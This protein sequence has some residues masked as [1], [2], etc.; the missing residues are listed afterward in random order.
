VIN[1]KTLLKKVPVLSED[2]DKTVREETKK[3]MVEFLRW[4]GPAFKP[5]L[6]SVKELIVKEVEA[7]VEKCTEKPKQTRYLRSQQVRAERSA[8]EGGD[9]DEELDGEVPEDEAVPDIDPFELLDPVDILSKLPKDFYEKCEAKKWQERKEA[10]EA[11]ETLVANPK[12]EPGDYGDLVRILKRIIGKDTN[13]V[14]VAIAGKCVTGLANGLKKKFSPYASSCIST[15]LEKFKEKKANV[16]TAMREAI[17]ACFVS[18]S[19]EAIQEDAVAALQNKNPQ[20]KM[21]TN[22][23]L[24][25]TFSKT[26][27]KI[28]SDKKLMKPYFTAIVVNLNESDPNV[29]DAAAEAIGVAMKHLGE[30]PLQPFISELEPIKLA[31]VKEM[32]EKAVITAPKEKAAKSAAPKA[33]PAKAAAAKPSGAKVVKKPA[34]AAKKPAPAANK[35]DSRD[36]D[37]MNNLYNARSEEELGSPDGQDDPTG[38]DDEGI[39]R[40]DI[41]GQITESLLNELADKNWKTRDAALDKICA[42]IS[43]HKHLKAS[44]GDLPSAL[45]LRLQDSNKNLATNTFLLCQ[46]LANAL[47]PNAKRHVFTLAAA[48]LS[49]L[50]DSKVH[51]LLNNIYF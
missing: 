43:K 34:A 40:V 46:N 51:I 36:D 49:G 44:L 19:L 7:E 32:C 37:D 38:G 23:F 42:M 27:F 20:V 48:M 4:L 45:V 8:A 22:A 12:L 26:P 14:V 10:M 35:R 21:E 17:D 9:G 39:V 33:A 50:S 13:V 18:T 30:K 28:M 5:M 24:S 16:V 31:K 1:I 47:G 11:L 2:R 6:N 15:I 29:R 41:S 3:L 25:R